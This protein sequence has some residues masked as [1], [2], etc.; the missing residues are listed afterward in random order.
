VLTT[1]RVENLNQ[2]IDEPLDAFAVACANQTPHEPVTNTS[3]Y[4]TNASMSRVHRHE[5]P[6]VLGRVVEQIDVEE[7]ERR[8]LTYCGVCCI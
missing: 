3:G 2:T 4:V 1:I 5:C 8:G 6:H 7:I